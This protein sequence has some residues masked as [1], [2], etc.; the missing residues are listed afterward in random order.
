[1]PAERLQKLLARAG[2]GSRRA[3]EA[4]IAEGRVRVD[5]HVA[6]LGERA[7]PDVSVIIVD[8]QPLSSTYDTSEVWALHKPAG[9]VVSATAER[10]RPSVYEL[11]PDAPPNL[12]Y[13]GRLDVDTSG[14][15]LL[16]TDGELVH[17]LS[18]PRYE[19]WK[20]YEAEVRGDLDEEALQRLRDG[21]E[22]EDGMSA[23]ARA[24]RLRSG[25]RALVRLELREGRK[26]EVRRMLAAVGTPVLALRRTS[27][28]TIHLGGLPEGQARRLTAEEAGSLRELVGL[29]RDD[30]AVP[31]AG[32]A[33]DARDAPSL[34]SSAP[35]DPAAPAGRDAI[36][37]D[38]LARSIAID[39]ATASGKSVVGRS[40]AEHLSLG[41]VDTGLMYRACTLA[42][43]ERGIDPEDEAAV[44]ALVRGLD[45]DLQWP[46]PAQPRAILDGEDVTP[47]LRQPEIERTVSLISRIPEVRDELVTRQRAL[48][49]RS[50]I[51][52]AGRDIGTRVLSEAR[53]KVFLEASTE[54]RARRRLGEELD[55]GRSTTFE[56]VLDET[57]RRDD[58]DSTGKRAIKRE[59]AAE[60]AIII[61]TDMLGIDEVVEVC[62]NA[63]RSANGP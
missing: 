47:R 39:G 56:R 12:R 21:V 15:L 54:V 2:Y 36:S 22:L 40:L 11:L 31:P 37:T 24:E 26:R 34:S 9:Y 58:M 14:L 52:M 45:L 51:V 20:T 61:D 3:A 10:G 46:D 17:R 27:V 29:P 44:I 28:G 32:A 16:S 30:A 50:P 33:V 35:I 41:F 13:V 42:V 62:L 63:Y 38:S 43:L 8:D 59:Q 48:A 6:T 18:H 25:P 55:A 49:A 57:R 23:P 19:V 7:D 1:M 53:T 60:D 4:V 5:G